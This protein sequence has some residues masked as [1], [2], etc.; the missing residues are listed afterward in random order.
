[1]HRAAIGLKDAIW[2]ICGSTM[3]PA[4]NS[5]EHM[6]A[7]SVF[8]LMRKA[9]DVD[10]R[11]YHTEALQFYEMQYVPRKRKHMYAL[12]AHFNFRGRAQH[13]WIRHNHNISRANERS[14][15]NFLI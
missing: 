14:F 8:N 4:A 11:H 3:L 6:H 10:Y 9:S 7:N 12:H 2:P 13:S 5:S 15:T 1:M